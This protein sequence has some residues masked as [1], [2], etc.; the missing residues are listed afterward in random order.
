[1]LKLA[2]LKERL[3]KT[4]HSYL[5][6]LIFERGINSLSLGNVVMG[7]LSSEAKEVF[8]EENGTQKLEDVRYKME[9]VGLD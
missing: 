1:M 2:M 5:R 6:R 4:F 3:L 9:F 8:K 7:T